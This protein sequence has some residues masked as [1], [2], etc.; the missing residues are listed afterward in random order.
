MTIVKY[1]LSTGVCTTAELLKLKQQH[2]ADYD[3]LIRM[4]HE[5]AKNLNV[6]IES[7]SA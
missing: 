5:Q 6:E 7:P 3:G 4:A 2:P 1:L